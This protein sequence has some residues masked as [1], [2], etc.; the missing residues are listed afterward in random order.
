MPLADLHI[1]FA[2][3][4]I[5]SLSP[6]I[7][8]AEDGAKKSDNYPKKLRLNDIRHLARSLNSPMKVPHGQ[9]FRIGAEVTKDIAS[10]NCKFSAPSQ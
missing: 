10:T 2:N 8:G 4:F 7:I 5:I 9:S 1:G 3:L 6:H